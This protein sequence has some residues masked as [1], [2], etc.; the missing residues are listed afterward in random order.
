MVFAHFL[1]FQIKI[2]GS[3]SVVLSP[4]FTIK[5]L[6]L[7]F[8]FWDNAISNALLLASLEKWFSRI[9]FIIYLL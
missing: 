3:P 1:I 5:R 8:I 4:S 7:S 2:K 6:Q 9:L